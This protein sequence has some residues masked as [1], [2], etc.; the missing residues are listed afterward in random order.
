MV[1]CVFFFVRG[2][3]DC[4]L[5]LVWCGSCM[6]GY[7]VYARLSRIAINDD[8]ESMGSQ[9]ATFYIFWVESSTR[10][11]NGIVKN[12]RDAMIVNI[13][14]LF[15]TKSGIDMI[16]ALGPGCGIVICN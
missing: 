15:A 4:P 6:M 2:S 11:D 14:F 7:G 5:A 10:F 8:D 9:H 3:F 12:S 13:F 16:N 1:V